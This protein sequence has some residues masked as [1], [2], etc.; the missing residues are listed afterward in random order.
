MKSAAGKRPP[1]EAHGPVH[2]SVFEKSSKFRKTFSHLFNVISKLSLFFF[3][4]VVQNSPTFMKK[5]GRQVA[6]NFT[7]M[8]NISS[9][10]DP[11]IDSPFP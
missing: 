8:I 5:Y 11:H 4:F 3:A 9:R 2:R 1:D 10:H 6:T 7:E